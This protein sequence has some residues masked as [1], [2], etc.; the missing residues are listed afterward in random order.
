MLTVTPP[1]WIVTLGSDD[2]TIRPT[3]NVGSL[4]VLVLAPNPVSVKSR[5]LYVPVVPTGIHE[6]SQMVQLGAKSSLTLLEK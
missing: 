1:V 6:S 4:L 5:T 3:S 2:S